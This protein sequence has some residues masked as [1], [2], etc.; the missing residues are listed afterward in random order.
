MGLW[1][2][3][4]LL[5]NIILVGNLLIV[6]KVDL[7]YSI[8]IRSQFHLCSGLRVFGYESLCL[9]FCHILDFENFKV[10]N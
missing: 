5:A 8:I 3:F 10:I 9:S 7:T 6:G 1:T 4:A 2:R